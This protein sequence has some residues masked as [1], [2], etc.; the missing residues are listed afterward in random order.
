MASE[1]VMRMTPR[2]AQ[3]VAH[4]AVEM[5][6]ENIDAGVSVDPSG[7]ASPFEP[8]STR[9]FARPIGGLTKATIKRLD[10]AGQIER[11]QREGGRQWIIVLG[12]YVALKRAMNPAW[13]GEVDLA[14]TGEMRRQIAVLRADENGIEIG[15]LTAQ[16]SRIAFYHNVAGAGKSR[17][18]RRFLDLTIEQREELIAM[19]GDATNVT[20]EALLNL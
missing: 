11:F 5:I 8:Y 6:Q 19:L 9:P 3:L 13:T 16:T 1:L 17:T 14:N 15:F 12:G 2:G 18:I 7:R 10:D 20:L 4:R